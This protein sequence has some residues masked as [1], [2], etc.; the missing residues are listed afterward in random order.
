MSDRDDDDG[1]VLPF[2]RV[3]VPNLDGD[4]K[5]NPAEDKPADDGPVPQAAATTPATVG[6]GPGEMTPPLHLTMP[7][8]PEPGRGE[9]TSEGA[10]VGP[11][12]ENPGAP[13]A[14]DA[15][16][17]AM[18]LMT[19]M[20]VAGAQGMW[21]RARQRQAH[22]DSRRANADKAK[23]AAQAARAKGGTTT[24]R[25]TKSGGSSGGGLGLGRRGSSGSG[26]KGGSG[27]SRGGS[28]GAKSSRGGGLSPL[29]RGS[30][31]GSR[32]GSAGG[33]AGGRG[34]ALTGG[35]R[36]SPGGS[37]GSGGGSKSGSGSPRRASGGQ[38]AST[39]GKSAAG[40][41]AKGLNGG[42]R[43]GPGAGARGAGGSKGPNG[44]KGAAGT[45]AATG[46]KGPT[47]DG[48]KPGD[49]GPK[50]TT[51]ESAK[52]ARPGAGSSAW[53]GATAGA[54]GFT[55][56][57][58]TGFTG[59]S[60]RRRQRRSH[61]QEPRRDGGKWSWE[62]DDSGKWSWQQE[63][64]QPG[65]PDGMRPPPAAR[66]YRTWAE[67][68]TPD[69]SAVA[70]AE[71]PALAAGAAPEPNTDPTQGESVTVSTHQPGTQYTA[72]DAEL[73]IHDVIEADA[74]MAEQILAG[75]AEAQNT[76][77]GCD[78]LFKWLESLRARV[79]EL[80]V[81]GSLEGELLNLMD[82]TSTVRS[83]A[84]AI[85][86]GLPGAAEAIATAGSN[87]ES[88][89]R[90]LADAVRDAGHARPAERDYHNE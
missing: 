19:A 76:V 42:S 21:H 40:P 4:P 32:G 48:T 52:K 34:G 12:P 75:V 43:G 47:S 86:E 80:R 71:R 57:A 49:G 68:V 82:Q 16:G 74:D 24:T 20:G 60:W 7:G 17:A 31:S 78:L 73:T 29:G 38:K 13:R 37:K 11:D 41:G 25:T 18:S 26:S 2:T 63:G 51:Q 83:S 30:G 39:G 70:S 8:I 65:G 85:L 81:P 36:S 22:A 66:P 35:R 15:L 53:W 28:G 55:A 79:V 9:D 5:D 64:S 84:A 72:D 88:R 54:A 33:R 3:Q 50:D 87:A 14:S 61:E 10:F 45:K 62:R 90:P 6:S 89:H 56:G 46:P 58:A 77:D 69:P 23:A 44:A 59:G 67:Q 1:Q 27:G